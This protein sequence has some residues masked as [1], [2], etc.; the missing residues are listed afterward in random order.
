[1]FRFSFLPS[2][3]LH[4]SAVRQKILDFPLIPC[5]IRAREGFR[6]QGTRTLGDSH[7]TCD[8][9]VDPDGRVGLHVRRSRHPSAS[10]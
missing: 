8:Q 2:D 1:M 10:R 5:I 3:V 9:D 7:E 4:T 6:S